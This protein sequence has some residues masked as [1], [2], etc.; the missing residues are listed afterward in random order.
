MPE[1]SDLT[2]IIPGLLYLSG[3]QGASSLDSLRTHGITVV[4][5]MTKEVDNY[6]ELDPAFEYHRCASQAAVARR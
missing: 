5:N 2:L 6:F 1:H 3:S 4:V